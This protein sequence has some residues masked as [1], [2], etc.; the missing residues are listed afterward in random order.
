M[1][2]VRDLFERSGSLQE[3]A[4]NRPLLLDQRGVVSLVCSGGVDVFTVRVRGRELAG[5]R[6]FLC[7]IPDGKALFGVSLDTTEEARGILAVGTSGTTLRQLDMSKLLELAAAA[8]CGE[9]AA[10]LVDDWL[11]SLSTAISPGVTPKK[12]AMLQP[13]DRLALPEGAVA[14]SGTG[15]VWVRH[16]EG[17]SHFSGM[18]EILLHAETGW[19][20]VS[21]RTWLDAVTHC[22]LETAT[23]TSLLTEGSLGPCVEAFHDLA[24]ACIRRAEDRT[25]HA[26]L[27]RI[28]EKH[29]ADRSVMDR[30]INLLAS[31]MEPEATVAEVVSEDRNPLLAACR[32]VGR[33]QGV[34]IVSP[35]DALDGARR[36]DPLHAIARASRVRTRRV[37]L[38]DNWW[39]RDNGPLLAFLE[40]GSEPVAL[41]P[42]HGH[43]YDMVDPA[44]GTRSR[45]TPKTADSLSSFAY[46]LYRPFPDTAMTALE[47]L[48]FGFRASLRQDALTMLTLGIAVGLLALFAPIATGIIFDKIIPSAERRQLMQLTAALTVMAIGT[49]LF[50]LTRGLAV[51]RLETK[52][53]AAVQTGVWDRLLR[54]P[55][56]FFRNYL[57]GDLARRSLGIDQ[58]RRLLTGATVS[59]LLGGLFSI[60][61]F[62]L[63][64]YY[65]ARL[66]LVAAGLV[67]VAVIVT[68]LTGL[69]KLRLERALLHIEGKIAGLVLQLITGVSK[70]HVAG[71]EARAFAVW[72]KDFTEQRRL[73]FKARS[74]QNTLAVFNSAFPVVASMFI[75]GSVALMMSTSSQGGE[76]SFSTGSFLAFNAAFGQFFSATLQ[77]SAVVLSLLLI[78][79]IY[80]RAKPILEGKPE[81]DIAKSDPGELSGEIELS[82]VSFRYHNDGPLVL[83]DVSLEA[84]PGEFVA[85]VGPSGAGK[86]SVLR[87]LLGFETPEN[88]SVYY[89]HQHL[90]TLDVQSVRRQIGVV[91]QNA[92]VLPG[93]IFENIVGSSPLTLE[94]ASE[95]A[96]MAGL[97]E[98]VEQ[99]PMGMHTFIMEGG[100]TL[101][102]GQRQRLLIARA[103]VGRPRI[104]LFDEATSALDNRT[105]AH[106]SDSLERLQT[107]RVVIAHR[108]STIVNA[109]RIYVMDHGRVV[110]QGSYRELLEQGGL[111]AEL[112]RRQLA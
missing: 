30:A 5:S 50:Q 91:L 79:P 97:D 43:Y 18:R 23:T 95:A 98:D 38:R 87:L 11:L 59:S 6:R 93:S 86:S 36:A 96:K 52:M 64:F 35:G 77:L 29:E 22:E 4:A 25:R 48:K 62:A 104:L 102:G 34:T 84:R 37:A 63:L 100:G 42:A 24:M 55:A 88:G 74:V 28:Q 17:Q 108:L 15:I 78:V 9:A 31:A 82:H 8:D 69:R 40:E 106:V 70:L 57:A 94:D 14:R 7:H 99:M 26:E 101:S 58:I 44:R 45:V 54:L 92:Q 53:G 103:V 60:F 75:F 13:G 109:D 39:T 72:A 61:S 10:A 1:T 85:I 56:P 80:E 81:V 41:L 89:D 20:A 3:L 33:E 16:T 83:D 110:E 49:G 19:V 111:F 73:A 51:L 46:M 32:L 66:A 105:Q 12:F 67:F 68:V 27:E 71:A 47:L 65:S 112:A 90:A 21:S 76:A 107:T 2:T